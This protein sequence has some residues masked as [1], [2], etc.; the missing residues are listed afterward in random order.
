MNQLNLE[1]EHIYLIELYIFK[2]NK[3]E[4]IVE[5]EILEK[6]ELDIE[7]RKTILDNSPMLHCKVVIPPYIGLEKKDKFDNK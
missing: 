2:V 5:I 6:S 7:Y 1:F 3:K 4:T